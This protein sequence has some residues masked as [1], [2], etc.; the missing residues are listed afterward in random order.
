M[1]ISKL[2]S[3]RVPDNLKYLLPSFSFCYIDILVSS[4]LTFWDENGSLFRYVQMKLDALETRTLKTWRSVGR[5]LK[6]G[7]D[8]LNLIEAERRSY[9][10]ILLEYLGTLEEVPTMREF[11]RALKICGRNDIAEYICKRSWVTKQH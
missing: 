4:V 8:I 5:E 6:V 10:E 3:E 1:H 7:P 9:T 11:V 2:C